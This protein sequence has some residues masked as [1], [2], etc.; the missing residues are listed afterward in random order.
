MELAEEK[1]PQLEVPNLRQLG[2]Q[3]FKEALFSGRIRPGDF[4]SQREICDLLDVP[5][6][7]VRESLKTL[8]SEG[9]VTLLPKRGV[10][11]IQVDK[12]AFRQAIDARI[13]IEAPAAEY[14]AKNAPSDLIQ[15]IKVETQAFVEKIGAE[16]D[17]DDSL[18]QERTRV[19]ML[20]HDT[21]MEFFGNPILTTALRSATEHVRIF[22]LNIAAN[23]KF[24]DAPAILEHMNIIDAFEARKV[25]EASAAMIAH[26]EGGFVRGFPNYS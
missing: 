13:V 2:H 4:V 16:T 19:D 7:P 25:S 26:L 21:V 10:R 20:L 18:H 8:E 22:R 15:K 11:V 17:S 6:G 9:I 14:F 3:R 12:T 24:F 1:K 5:L 23:D